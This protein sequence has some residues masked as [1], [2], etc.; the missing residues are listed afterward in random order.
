MFVIFVLDFSKIT[1]Y[2]IQNTKYKI[3]NTKYKMIKK[4]EVSEKA[5]EKEIR[6]A[7][8]KAAKKCHPDVNQHLNREEQQHLNKKFM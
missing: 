7:Y 6:K 4:V 5:S 1:K 2:K 8:F 3:Q